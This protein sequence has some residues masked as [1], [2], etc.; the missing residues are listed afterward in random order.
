MS[1]V[2]NCKGI[3]EQ[4]TFYQHCWSLLF[5][6]KVKTSFLAFL[7]RNKSCF[8]NISK[9]F[10]M[11]IFWLIIHVW[12]EFGLN[13]FSVLD[14]RGIIY[15]HTDVYELSKN[16]FFGGSEDPKMDISNNNSKEMFHTVLF[17]LYTIVNLIK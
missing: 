9:E 1:V 16:N 15:W 3:Q 11:F 17:F 6:L 12:C 5:V 10:P 14:A 7:C 4:H 13:K 8:S 2:L